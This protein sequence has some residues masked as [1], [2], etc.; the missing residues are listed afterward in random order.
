MSICV[1][2]GQ[3]SQYSGMG[4]DIYQNFDCAR[5]IFN[6]VDESLSYNLSNIIFNGSAAEL[7]QTQNAQ[8][9]LMCVSMAFV[10]VLKKEFGWDFSNFSFFAG[11]SLGEYTALCASGVL[12]LSQTA[13]ILKKRGE[14]MA[15]C[16]CQQNSACCMAAIL[17]LGV[18]EVE[19]AISQYSKINQNYLVVIAN[20]NSFEQIVISGHEQAIDEICSI[21]KNM[22]AKRSI[23]LE[24]AGAFHSPLMNLASKKLCQYFEENGVFCGIDLKEDIFNKIIS[25]YTGVP[26]TLSSGSISEILCQQLTGRVRWT[27]SIE[28]ATSHGVKKCVEIGAGRV[29]S[30]LSKKIAPQLEVYT[31]NSLS[32]VSSICRI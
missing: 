8:P 7:K 10:E 6:E 9:A 28:Y 25:N 15:E 13:I 22:G 24:V 31:I 30:G 14:F 18:S 20:D 17:G 2:P 26:Y 21:A 1:F 5:K 29:L 19:E 12:S 27:Q 3:G 23:K 11:H 4:H 32:D 16:S